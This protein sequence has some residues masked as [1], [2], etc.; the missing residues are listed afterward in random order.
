[1]RTFTKNIISLLAVFSPILIF[2]LTQSGIAAVLTLPAILSALVIYDRLQD[3]DY[4]FPRFSIK[5]PSISLKSLSLYAFI[6]SPSAVIAA[7]FNTTLTIIGLS[8]IPVTMITNYLLTGV[9]GLRVGYIQRVEELE[10]QNKIIKSIVYTTI[11]LS[12]I[13]ISILSIALTP[14]YFVGFTIIFNLLAI[15]ELLKNINEPV[16]S[17]KIVHTQQNLSALMVLPNGKRVSKDEYET[18]TRNIINGID[19]KTGITVS[20]SSNKKGKQDA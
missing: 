20:F 16:P 4:E 14:V 19:T 6:F 2:I 5:L 7:D 13:S 3:A 1:M 8:I 10:I 12:S 17:A 9:K 18:L 11:F 15:V